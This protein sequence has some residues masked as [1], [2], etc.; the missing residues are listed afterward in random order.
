MWIGNHL[1]CFHREL[2][3]GSESCRLIE[4]KVQ[5]YLL[6]LSVTCTQLGPGTGTGTNI[7]PPVSVQLG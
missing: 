6:H 2:L 4:T 3:K 7:Q 5:L 1:S